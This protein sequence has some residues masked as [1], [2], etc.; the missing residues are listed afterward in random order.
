[1]LGSAAFLKDTYAWVH[2]HP[3]HREDMEWDGLDKGGI[4][5]PY[6]PKYRKFQRW[7]VLLKE[8][9]EGESFP[10]DSTPGTIFFL[11]EA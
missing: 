8:L 4:P 1:M 6:D 9:P 3:H 11:T 7:K 2:D 5:G 10:N